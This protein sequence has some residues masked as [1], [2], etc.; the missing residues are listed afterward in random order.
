MEI[1]TGGIYVTFERMDNSKKIFIRK[2]QAMRLEGHCTTIGNIE[3][4]PKS[5]MDILTH[6]IAMPD[7]KVLTLSDRIITIWDNGIEIHHTTRLHHDHL[8]TLPIRFY[9]SRE[10]LT[11]IEETA[12]SIILNDSITLQ[13]TN[14]Q[15]HAKAV[16][17]LHKGTGFDTY[18]V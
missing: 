14:E 7:A 11:S 6:L 15:E 4:H 10:S 13:F 12:D 17:F 16:T 18:G 1:V 2:P 3:L 9:M 5:Y 8:D